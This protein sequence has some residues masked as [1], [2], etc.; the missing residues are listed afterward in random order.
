MTEIKRQ[1]DRETEGYFKTL[2][3]TLGAIPEV[4]MIQ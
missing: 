4:L 3:F 2:I 1:A